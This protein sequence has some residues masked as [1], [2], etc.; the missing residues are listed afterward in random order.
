MARC[1][2]RFGSFACADA[3]S[4]ISS[5]ASSA[6]STSRSSGLSLGNPCFAMSARTS[7]PAA[8]EI[9]RKAGG[10]CARRM[11]RPDAMSV[12]GS[13][14]RA[15]CPHDDD[16]EEEDDGGDNGGDDE[17]RLRERLLLRLARDGG[18]DVLGERHVRQ[19]GLRLSRR[20]EGQRGR[21]VLDAAFGALRDRRLVEADE[22]R[23]LPRNA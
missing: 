9:V 22:R 2:P 12:G 17:A 18:R 3:A 7:P 19:V 13:Y 10:I 1:I 5:S 11:D 8:P 4:A 14:P 16:D 6:R 23:D 20:K 15:P 21:E